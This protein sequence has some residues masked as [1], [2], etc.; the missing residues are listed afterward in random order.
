MTDSGPFNWSPPIR[1]IFHGTLVGGKFSAAVLSAFFSASVR[2][3]VEDVPLKDRADFDVLSG[4]DVFIVDGV[5]FSLA[6]SR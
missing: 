2:S 4:L 6:E 1:S 5:W 3:P